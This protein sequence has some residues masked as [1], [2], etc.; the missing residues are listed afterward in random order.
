MFKVLIVDDSVVAREYLTH[1]L[2]SDPGISVV[3]T[4]SSGLEAI[5][6]IR[7]KSPD[8][9]TMDIHMPDID[10]METTRR[11]ME[12]TPVPVIIVSST[13]RTKDTAFSFQVLETGALAVLLKPPAMNHPE[14]ESTKNELIETIKVMSEVKV[15]KR[16]RRQ[17][18]YRSQSDPQVLSSLKAARAQIEVIAIGCSTGGPQVLQTILSGLT[19]VPRSAI[20]ITQHISPGF[21]EGFLDW[22]STT[23]PIPIKLGEAGEKVLPGK[24]YLAPENHHMGVAKRQ[25]ILSKDPPRFGLRPSVDFLFRSVAEEYGPASIG[26]ILTG[27]G[28]DGADALKRMRDKGAVTIA[29]NKESCIVFGM[30]QEAIK[31]GGA[32]YVLSIE[33]II[34]MINSFSV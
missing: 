1:I 20:L 27:M 23:T 25:I 26:I 10:G 24:I 18:L 12:E 9:V 32:D 33:E 16:S 22:L 2:S 21:T 3:G 7:T 17:R 14:F 15:V 19:P 31:L 5:D 8:V 29:Q 13:I 34:R 30:P 4:A 28:A 11:I 6:L